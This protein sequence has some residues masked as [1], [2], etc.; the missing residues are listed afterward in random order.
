MYRPI[1][2][3]QALLVVAA[4][5]CVLVATPSMAQV[6]TSALVLEA[7]ALDLETG[8]EGE[9]FS[10]GLSTEAWRAITRSSPQLCDRRE[11]WS[12]PISTNSRTW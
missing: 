12:R 5:A 4:V 7:E 2:G 10:A 1:L 9:L 8:M 11:R 6:Q 3:S